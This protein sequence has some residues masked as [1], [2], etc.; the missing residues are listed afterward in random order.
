M[1]KESVVTNLVIISGSSRKE[2]SNLKL[3]R[4][5][6]SCCNA[7]GAQATHIELESYPMPIYS[8]DLEDAEGLPSSVKALQAALQDADGIIFTCPEYNG[9]MT[10]LL[11][12]A[13]DWC[14]RSETASLSLSAFAGKSV[15]VASASPGPGGG[16]RAATHLKSLLMGIGCHVSPQALVIAGSYGAFDENGEFIDSTIQQ[17]AAVQIDQFITFTKKLKSA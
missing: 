6:E 12:N 2:S 1:T 17:R 10:P 7:G 13:I 14:T 9:F 15:F 16:S 5:L 4:I 3:A 8:G 11:L